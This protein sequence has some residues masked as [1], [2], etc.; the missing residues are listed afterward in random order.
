[1]NWLEWRGEEAASDWH[2]LARIRGGSQRAFARD[3]SHGITVCRACAR[4]LPRSTLPHRLDSFAHLTMPRTTTNQRVDFKRAGRKRWAVGLAALTLGLMVAALWVVS[5]WAGVTYTGTTALIDFGGGW[6]RYL[7][8]PL[9]QTPVGWRMGR[10]SPWWYWTARPGSAPSGS[11]GTDISVFAHLQYPPPSTFT[12]TSVVFW[13]LPLLLWAGGAV[14][15]WSGRRARKRAM[16]NHCLG[17]GYDLASLAPCTRCPECSK[18][19]VG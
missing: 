8:G 19:M 2:G 16:V 18:A 9:G 1:M 15:L 4:R 10:H 11:S 5:G 14:A 12:S 13:P 17:F 6:A 3:G 7:H